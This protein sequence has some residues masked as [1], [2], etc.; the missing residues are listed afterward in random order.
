M[1]LT[2]LIVCR[3]SLIGLPTCQVGQ[4]HVVELR[5]LTTKGQVASLH[6]LS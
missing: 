4:V 1:Y 2:R 3:W 5:A 6:T